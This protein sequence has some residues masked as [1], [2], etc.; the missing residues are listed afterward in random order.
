MEEYRRL[1][2][3]GVDMLG[4]AYELHCLPY[5]CTFSIFRGR[6]LISEIMNGYFRGT[7]GLEGVHNFHST[8]ARCPPYLGLFYKKKYSKISRSR[9]PDSRSQICRIDFWDYRAC[10]SGCIHEGARLNQGSFDKV[11]T[12]GHAKAMSRSQVPP[13]RCLNWLSAQGG[14]VSCDGNQTEGITLV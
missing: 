14:G 12:T 7:T 10:L 13:Q 3:Y 11:Y 8:A 9:I 4:Q 2:T 6:P 1:Y 5:E